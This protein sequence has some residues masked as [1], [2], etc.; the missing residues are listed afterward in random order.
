MEQQLAG[1]ASA[2]AAVTDL[3]VEAV[4]TPPPPPP[5]LTAAAFFDVDNTLVH[6]SSLEIGRA[7]V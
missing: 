6:G 1:E 2:E 5:D 3:A 4:T 7:H